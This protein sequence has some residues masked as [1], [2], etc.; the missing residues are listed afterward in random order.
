[1]NLLSRAPQAFTEEKA[2]E[3]AAILNADEDDD[4]TYTVKV[5]EVITGPYPAVI[6]VRE[7]DGELVALV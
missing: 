1:M 2:K 6:E 3:V 4:L 5:A 7:E